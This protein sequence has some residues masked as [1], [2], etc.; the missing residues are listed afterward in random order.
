MHV[1]VTRPAADAA[2]FKARLGA[3]GHTV[4][5]D[6]LVTIETTV[7]PTLEPGAARVLAATSRNALRALEGHAALPRLQS[8]PVFTVGP[9]TAELARRLG[10]ADVRPGTAT[11][12]DLVA[13][14]AAVGLPVLHLRGEKTAFDL[15]GALAAAGIA[16]TETVVYRQVPS[17]HLRPETIAAVKDGSLD[18]VVLMSPLTAA[19]WLTLISQA[20]CDDAAARLRYACLS[21][22]IAAAMAAR[23]AETRVAARP[24]A[25]EMLALVVAMAAQSGAKR[26][27]T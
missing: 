13:P 18:T 21:A 3:L 12:A 20:G 14:L 27:G 2:E 26:S 17:T 19:T 22:G 23:G 11:A 5:L 24:N 10:F 1:L 15:A 9:G 7:P 16:V 8:L 6:P 4:L 25:E